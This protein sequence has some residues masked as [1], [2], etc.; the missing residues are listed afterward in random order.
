MVEDVIV[1]CHWSDTAEG[2]PLSGERATRPADSDGE[3]MVKELLDKYFASGILDSV[4]LD[5]CGTPFQKKVWQCAMAIHP[6][7]VMSYGDLARKVGC[8]DGQRA[9]AQAL[10]YNPIH[11]FVPCHRIV[12]AHSIGGYAAGV[13]LKRKLLELEIISTELQ[14]RWR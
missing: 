11:L 7:S 12:G 6:G 8:S 4:K 10:H 5:L 14:L 9:V 1:L 13:E 3:W 2:E